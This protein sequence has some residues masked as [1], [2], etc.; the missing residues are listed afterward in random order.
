MTTATI[1]MQTTPSI[2]FYVS[3]LTPESYNSKR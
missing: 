3:R 2:T 1:E